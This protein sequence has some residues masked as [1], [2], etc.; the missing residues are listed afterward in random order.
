[1]SGQS[2]RSA[3]ALAPRLQ[4]WAARGG[5]SNPALEIRDHLARGGDLTPQS[6]SLLASNLRIPEATVRGIA[7]YYAD[8]EEAEPSLRVCEGTSCMLAGA[9]HVRETL[10]RQGKHCRGVYCLGYCDRSPAVLGEG[11]Q[12]FVFAPDFEPRRGAHPL[13]ETRAVCEPAIVTRR[14]GTGASSLEVARSLGA[15]SALENALQ[16]TPESVITAMEESGER[17]RGGAGFSTGRKWRSCAETPAEQRYVIANGDEGDPGA[18]VDR[19]LMEEDPH[20]ILEGLLLCAYAVG[21]TKGIVYIRSEYPRAIRIMEQA[22]REAEEAGLLGTAI[23]DTSFHCEVSVFPGM[24]SYVCGEETAMIRAIEGLRGEVQIRPPYPT[25]QGLFG[26]PTIV[27]NVETLIN[28]AFI[29][30]EG[31]ARYRALGTEASSGTKAICLNHVFA[32]PGIVEVEFGVP[33]RQVI[34]QWG[35]GARDGAKLAAVIVGGPMGSIVLPEDWDVPI[36]YA[37][38]QERGIQFGH[39]GVV[40]LPEDTDFRALLQ[41]WIQFMIDESCGKCVPCRL[42]SQCASNALVRPGSDEATTHARL[43]EIFTTMEQG[44]L[45]A[46]GQFMPGPMRQLLQHFGDRIFNLEGS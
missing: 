26:M 1:M 46:F 27:N 42:G 38:M 37:A 16:D 30:Q 17:G 43:D 20:G 21:A 36:C 44:S 34:E 25:Q 14:V 8:L 23:L 41:H 29:L 5:T 7:S 13:P 33:L 45:C 10:N 31:A 4:Y 22:I 15:Y 11:D 3:R 12:P 40:A 2:Q 28:V 35:G 24:G 19:V 6:I 39:G 9:D 32:R 18:F